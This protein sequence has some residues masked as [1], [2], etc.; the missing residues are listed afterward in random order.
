MTQVLQRLCL[1]FLPFAFLG[2]LALG[3]STTLAQENQSEKLRQDKHYVAFLAG[4]LQ[5]RSIESAVVN[6]DDAIVDIKN[7]SGSLNNGT[8]VIG[9]HISE[10]FHAEVRAG[11]G[12]SDAKIQQDLTLGIDYFVSW[13]M[14]IHYPL[15]DFANIYGQFG[16]SHIQGT[17]ELRNPDER[18]NSRYRDFPE[19]FPESSF[20]VSWLAGIDLELFDSTFLVLEGGRLFKDTETDVSAFQFS[21]GLRYEF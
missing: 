9:G 14:G 20:S 21:T 15:T 12:I 11:G 19:E 10:L 7:D 1:T 5:I 8:L 17:A 6:D 13:Y 16:F 18:R 4:N 3:A 2:A